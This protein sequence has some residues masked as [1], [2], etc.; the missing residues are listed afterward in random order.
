MYRVSSPGSP[1]P[2]SAFRVNGGELFVEHETP[3]DASDDFRGTLAIKPQR[4]HRLDIPVEATERTPLLSTDT[5][6][7]DEEDQPWDSD[8]TGVAIFWEEMGTLTKYTLP[9]FGFVG[10]PRFVNQIPTDAGISTHVLEYSLQIA[11]VVSIG[12]ISTTALAAVTLGSMSA[13]VSG[14]SIIN[15]F[16]GALDTLLPS[17]W[18]SSTP[19]LVGLWSQRMGALLPVLSHGLMVV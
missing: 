19:Q 16:V 10:Q 1:T 11:S 8:K 9:V 3:Y 15:G 13:T 18:T 2:E 17:A 14:F 6:P 7:R 4:P 5:S 12:H